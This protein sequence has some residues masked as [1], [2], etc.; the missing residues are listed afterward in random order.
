MWEN[1][2]VTQEEEERESLLRKHITKRRVFT[3]LAIIAGIA[4]EVLYLLN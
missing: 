3:A 1:K 2:N 4:A